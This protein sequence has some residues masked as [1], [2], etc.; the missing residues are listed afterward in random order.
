MLKKFT[1]FSIFFIFIVNC[2]PA[3]ALTEFE[4]LA[5]NY[6]LNKENPPSEKQMLSACIKDKQSQ[7][8]IS[9]KEKEACDHIYTAENQVQ[10]AYKSFMDACAYRKMANSAAQMPDLYNQEF[11]NYLVKH[12]AI[13]LLKN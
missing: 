9:S 7:I 1:T 5:K 13:Y 8:P 10:G 6:Y 2:I 11:V 3:F 4:N 12:R